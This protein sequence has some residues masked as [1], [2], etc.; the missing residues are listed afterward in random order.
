MIRILFLANA[1]SIHTI[2]WVNAI[3]SK[4]EFKVCLVSQHLATE[5]LHPSISIIY[6]PVKSSLGYFA[7]TF[8]VRRVI[9]EFNP[10]LVHAHYISGFGTL[11]RMTGFNPLVLSV[12]GADIYDFPKKSFMHKWLIRSN[13]NRANR[14]L[15]TSEVMAREISKYTEK[16]VKIT[17]FGI[18][19][20]HFKKFE[21]QG[22]FSKDDIVIGTI[23]T[24]DIKYGIEYLIR[25]F[26]LVK[27]RFP[28]L[29]LKLL[30]VG[31]GPQ[32]SY[33]KQLTLDLNLADVTFFAGKVKHSDIANYQNML[34]VSVSL[35][36]LDSESFGVAIVEASACQKP[37]VVSNVGGLPEVVEHGVTGFVVDK[38]NFVEAA[39]AIQELILDH[40]LRDSMGEAGRKRVESL[41]NWEVNVKNMVKIYREIVLEHQYLNR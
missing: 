41:F 38:Q 12:W 27:D 32:E 1:A 15:S 20:K 11:A 23:K 26:K 36:I 2:R 40:D 5:K 10:H 31:G 9:K 13:L 37:V 33:L 18:D 7:N 25:A 8:F 28:Q 3:A 19:L 35:S 6:A 14:V 17:P 21:A 30:I 29:P 24:L 34:S 39:D 4:S 22:P 16:K